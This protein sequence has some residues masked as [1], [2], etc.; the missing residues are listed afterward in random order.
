MS[1]THSMALVKAFGISCGV[2]CAKIVVLNLYANYKRVVAE[3]EVRCALLGC[4]MVC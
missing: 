4:P 1:S 3:K 2:V